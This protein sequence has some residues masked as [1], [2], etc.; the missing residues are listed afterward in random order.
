MKI[1]LQGIILLG[2]FLATGSSH[3]M[4]CS[5]EKVAQIWV[6]KAKKSIEEQERL[7][8]RRSMI[9]MFDVVNEQDYQGRTALHRLMISKQVTIGQVQLLIKNGARLDIATKIGQIPY[10]YGILHKG[11]S[12]PDE[13]KEQYFYNRRIVL[14]IHCETLSNRLESLVTHQYEI[15]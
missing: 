12:P 2:C 1:G 4:Y 14:L 7:V 8:A 10:E 13:L 15:K 3:A 5:K 9:T 11:H 6:A